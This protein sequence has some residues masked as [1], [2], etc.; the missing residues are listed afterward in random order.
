MEREK[1]F[2]PSETRERIYITC[3]EDERP[4]S[5]DNDKP[6]KD[7]SELPPELQKIFEDTQRIF[8]KLMSNRKRLAQD[9]EKMRALMGGGK[10]GGNDDGRPNGANNGILSQ[11]STDLTERAQKNMLDIC[12]GRHEEILR[13]AEI[14]CRRKKNNPVLIG[15]PG[16]GKS[17]IV[18]GLA[19]CIANDDIPD[20]LQGKRI[21]SLNITALVAG[22][23][24]RGDF[25]ERINA[26]INELE[27]RH[28]IILFIDEIHTIMGAGGASG[29]L[30]TA[31][32]LKP[33]LARGTIQCIGATTLDEY[34]KSIEKDGAL[35]RRFQKIIV[36]EPTQKETLEI[37]KNICQQYQKHHRV[38]FPEETL[39]A[40]VHLA[41]QYITERHFPDKAIDILDEVGAH[42]RLKQGASPEIIKTEK[43]LEKL[44]SQKRHAVVLQDFEMA[45]Y[46]RDKQHEL[47]KK[48]EKL[49]NG[50]DDS[51]PET[52]VSATLNDVYDV[53][54]RITG[55]PVKTLSESE[56]ERMRHLSPTLKE[57]VIGQDAAIDSVVRSIIRSK[58]GV[59]NPARPIGVFLFLGPTGVGKTYL[60][61]KIAQEIYG[62]PD[63]LIRIDM[64]EYNESFNTSRLVGAPPGYV[65]YDD[66]GQLT[67]RVRRKTYSVVLL[68]EIEKAHQNVFNMLLQVLDEGRLTDGN[69]RLINFRNT[70][71]IMTSNTGTRQLKDFGKGIGFNTLE[72]ISHDDGQYTKHSEAI[73][74]KALERQFAPEFLNRLDEVITFRQLSSE[75]IRKIVDIELK[76]LAQRIS[77][78]GYKLRISD[79]AKAFLAEKG[80]DV[81]YGARPL[82][83]AIQ[84]YVEDALCDA[85]ISMAPPK[86]STLKVKPDRKGDTLICSI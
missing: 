67:E 81:Q 76:G 69:G 71:I 21:L 8:D 75:S 53:I 82:K 70:I 10:M 44:R 50:N 85:I 15:E 25:E 7:D 49:R 31:N 59:K 1:I 63:A 36:E 56:I 73:I 66:G 62:T 16:V 3:E 12:V 6:R 29:S 79:K 24:Y 30:D 64:S 13:V 19:Q 54:S 9:T 57:H 84:R 17:A 27:G 65:G 68:D 52:F 26:I 11:F 35:E 22:T 46:F 20:V 23:K 78:M 37:L 74:R 43:E 28:D 47:E 33:A 5:Q 39:E 60:A 38:T 32:I 2:E 41:G 40:C 80:Y 72:K 55:V 4:S 34:R 77:E 83:R 51:D 48:L 14:L 86:G 61:Q 45:A 18:E 58:I 42:L